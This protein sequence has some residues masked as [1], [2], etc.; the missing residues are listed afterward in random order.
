MKSTVDDIELNRMLDADPA[1]RLKY[2]LL[3]ILQEMKLWVIV[4]GGEFLGIGGDCETLT[5][6]IWPDRR[7]AD[8]IA[9]AE[10]PDGHTEQV[11][12][13]A[14][15]MTML[16]E[17]EKEG[18]KICVFPDANGLG[19]VLE[20]SEF[21]ERVLILGEKHEVDWQQE[22]VR[23]LQLTKLRTEIYR[24]RRNWDGASY[25][26]IMAL[27]PRFDE[28]LSTA[29]VALWNH[30]SLDG[31]YYDM[32]K[33]FFGRK[34]YQPDQFAL[35]DFC[36]YGHADLKKSKTI[37]C[38]SF[39]IR[40]EHSYDWLVFSLSMSDLENIFDIGSFPMEADPEE[41]TMWK[42]ELDEYLLDLGR[43]VFEHVP[44]ETAVVGYDVANTL[45]LL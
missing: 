40:T 16:E 39:P 4:R 29:T 26:V 35:K 34:R 9:R 17:F 38:A 21:R 2:S 37:I 12:L 14:F 13:T 41:C 15:M 22:H 18:R 32:K 1:D 10:S 11:S 3:K 8:P 30:R 36:V 24:E 7:Y 44:F 25:D 27:G 5:L 28:R 45:T 31:C 6:A 19:A 20:P 33:R 42:P 43:H 23:E